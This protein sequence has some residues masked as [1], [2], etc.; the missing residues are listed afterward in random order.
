MD[1][2]DNGKFRLERVK[3]KT[4]SILATVYEVRQMQRKDE[5]SGIVVLLINKLLGGQSTKTII[6]CHVNKG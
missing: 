3:A 6:K 2:D 5:A 1:E 4:R